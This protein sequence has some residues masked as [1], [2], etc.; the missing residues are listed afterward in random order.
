MLCL[1]CRYSLAA[2]PRGVCP[3][4]GR[5]FD[6]GDAATFFVPRRFMLS[7]GWSRAPDWGHFLI[8]G[9]AS[10][11]L[12]AAYWSISTHRLFQFVAVIVWVVLGGLLAI[13]AILR[14]APPTSHRLQVPSK[15]FWSRSLAVYGILGVTL[16]LIQLELPLKLQFFLHRSTLETIANKLSAY[17]GTVL[18]EQGRHPTLPGVDAAFKV[19][20]GELIEI[21]TRPNRQFPWNDDA[22]WGMDWFEYREYEGVA[23]FRHGGPRANS[24]H[25]L[26]QTL[27]YERMWGDWYLWRFQ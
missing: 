19:P 3:E 18:D 26:L 13:R 23:R 20:G 25:P 5:E 14:L 1:G 21:E 2:L 9:L 16:L 6:P 24:V 7:A 11:L 17:E 12:L 4:C 27:Q 22:R 10:L 8:A 15:R